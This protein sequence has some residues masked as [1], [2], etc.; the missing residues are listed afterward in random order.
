MFFDFLL[1]STLWIFMLF[2]ANVLMNWSKII[3]VIRKIDL[4]AHENRAP[5]QPYLKKLKFW[6]FCKISNDCIFS[7]FWAKIAIKQSKIIF[8]IA[9]VYFKAFAPSFSS[10]SFT[11]LQILYQNYD[12][13]KSKWRC[14]FAFVS[15][16]ALRKTTNAPIF[17]SFMPKWLLLKIFQ[18]R[19]AR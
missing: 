14:K 6:K 11:V 13:N 10:T 12:N 1:I 9:I 8:W 3:F 4:C 5:S 7:A 2:R 18:L 19:C 17:L 15:V 16:F